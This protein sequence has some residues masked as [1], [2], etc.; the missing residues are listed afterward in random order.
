[1]ATH[2]AA[3]PTITNVVCAMNRRSGSPIWQWYQSLFADQSSVAACPAGCDGKGYSFITPRRVSLAHPFAIWLPEVRR[4]RLCADAGP[5]TAHN[6]TDQE[7]R[8]EEAARRPSRVAGFSHVPRTCPNVR[9][10]RGR[11]GGSGSPRALTGR[12][13]LTLAECVLSGVRAS[14]RSISQST[15]S[16]FSMLATSKSYI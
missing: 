13:N 1:M 4:T 5:F 16:R 6:L 2:N 9:G 7:L 10:R 3:T 15:A 14:A 11:K 12:N 8:A